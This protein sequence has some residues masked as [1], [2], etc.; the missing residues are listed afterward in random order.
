MVCRYSHLNSPVLLRTYLKDLKVQL[1]VMGKF[2]QKLVSEVT[3]NSFNDHGVP[4]Q[5]MDKRKFRTFNFDI[6]R[7][8]FASK[9]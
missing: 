6:F 4:E 5:D 8:N 2:F 9:Q 1:F 7:S 3:S